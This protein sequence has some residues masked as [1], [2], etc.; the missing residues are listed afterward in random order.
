MTKHAL[1]KKLTNLLD[2]YC[3]KNKI[4]AYVKYE[5]SSL[6]TMTNVFKFVVKC[7]ALSLDKNFQG[8]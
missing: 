2:E 1:G 5:G 7:E 4:I 6:N 3:L 8:T